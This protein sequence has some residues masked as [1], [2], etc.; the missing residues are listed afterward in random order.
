MKYSLEEMVQRNH[1]YCIVDEVDSIL[2]DESRTPLVISGKVEDKSNLYMTANEFIKLLQKQDYELD[3]K[4]KML[5]LVI[6]V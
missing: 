4:T 2:I 6:S 1:H 3:E 5:F